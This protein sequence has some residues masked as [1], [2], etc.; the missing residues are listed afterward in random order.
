MQ[1][2]FSVTT[3]HQSTLI[4]IF[5][6]E[7]KRTGTTC[8]TVQGRQAGESQTSA[9]ATYSTGTGTGTK[10]LRV[11]S[12]NHGMLEI[13]RLPRHYTALRYGITVAH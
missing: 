3:L 10:R 4:T 11:Q 8:S 7:L 13:V 1:T 9:S 2:T 12:K 5:S 6:L